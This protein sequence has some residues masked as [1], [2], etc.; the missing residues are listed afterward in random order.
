MNN[1]SAL[2][3]SAPLA[4]IVQV[5]LTSSNRNPAKVLRSGRQCHCGAEQIAVQNGL[6]LPTVANPSL[7]L[8]FQV[9]QGAG[10]HLG[11]RWRRSGE[12]VLDDPERVALGQIAG[13]ATPRSP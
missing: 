10:L 7:T 9:G 11:G 6:D 4:L 1:P 2:S 5:V 13:V 12:V 3:G 8:H